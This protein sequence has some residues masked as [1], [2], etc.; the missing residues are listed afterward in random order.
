MK[1]FRK[2]LAMVMAVVMVM[3]VTVSAFAT[4][5]VTTY[6][7]TVTSEKT[8][9]TYEAYQIFKGTLFEETVGGNTVKTLSDIEWGAGVDD[10]TYNTIYTE[11]AAVTVTVNNVTYYP[12]TD[13][14]DA[15]GGGNAL[16]SAAAVARALA[17]YPDAIEDFSTI[18]NKYLTDT[19]TGTSVEDPTGT[20]KISNME[21]GYYLIK[22]EDGSV[23]ALGDAYTDI[24]L[25]VVSNVEV[26][27]KTVYPSSSKTAEDDEEDLCIGESV[28]YTITG[29]IP[30][31]S[32]YTSYTYTFHDTLSKGLTF[33]DDMTVTV[34][35]GST[36]TD[37]TQGTTYYKLV[38]GV[39]EEATEATPDPDTTYYYDGADLTAGTGYTLGT[40]SETDGTTKITVDVANAVN[41][42]NSCVVVKYSAKLNSGA[43][44]GDAGNSNGAYLEYS[45]N[46]ND[47]G[48]GKTNEEKVYTWTFEIDF[49]K[50]DG[51]TANDPTPTTLK[52]AQFVLYRVVSG[53]TYYATADE[54]TDGTWTITGWTENAYDSNETTKAT[55]FDSDADGVF[56]IKG[57]D[58]GTYQLLEIKAPDGYNS[59][60]DPIPVVISAE[61]EDNDKDGNYD[62][63][64]KLEAT[65]GGENVTAG[66]D[67]GIIKST[68]ANNAGSKMPSTGGIGVGVFFVGGVALI[69]V[70]LGALTVLKLRGKK[71]N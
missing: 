67:T 71:T 2:L 7:I 66:K 18:I 56:K 33:N 32:A 48:T 51:A 8:G 21:A 20:Y 27:A 39:L 12:F 22:D 61:Y 43:V 30:D 65:V 50:I 59:I 62:T 34:Y 41:Y 14:P 35:T 49:T 69:V 3:L 4:G 13:D 53:T 11:L 6:T 70:A 10:T 55:V 19:P 31:V 15:V 52:G 60:T 44:V 54:N 63:L 9:H 45:N 17:D 68:I 36:L 64:T 58:V 24:M 23:S 57:L 42:S 25:Q 29:T 40:T 47:N 46:P 5:N 37:F 26:A 38:D 16:T 1:T 28:H